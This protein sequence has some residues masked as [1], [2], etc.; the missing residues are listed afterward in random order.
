MRRIVLI[1]LAMIYYQAAYSQD[2]IPG[3]V[4]ES[5]AAQLEGAKGA[6]L[7]IEN[8]KKSVIGLGEVEIIPSMITNIRTGEKT[9]YIIVNTK[10]EGSPNYYASII[11]YDEIPSCIEALEY[12]MNNEITSKPENKV[13][14][15]IM[16]RDGLEIGAIWDSSWWR[17]MFTHGKY[18]D[19]PITDISAKNI[20]K[21][22]EML[23]SGKEVLDEHLN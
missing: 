18:I 2:I 3:Y 6:F 12:I 11:D 13:H 10:R 14:V 20:K 17:T 22:I 15:F 21:V 7:K 9:P 4:T 23:K 5:K 16:T 8:F 19:N 1:V